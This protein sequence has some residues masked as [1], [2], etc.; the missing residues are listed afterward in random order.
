MTARDMQKSAH[1]DKALTDWLNTAVQRLVETLRP[2]RI[3]LFG[4]F[5]RC[6][7]GRHSDLDLIIIWDT[8]LGPLERIGRALELLADAPRPVDV[9]VYTPREFQERCD[10][11]FLRGIL[12][13]AK[14]LYERREA[15]S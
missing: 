14:V 3:L 2:E 5:A 6:T 10:L 8:D 15:P 7:A 4:S 9:L 13:E 1:A 11:P 12:R